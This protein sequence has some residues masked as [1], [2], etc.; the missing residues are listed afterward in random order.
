MFDRRVPVLFFTNE[1]EKVS[2]EVT[3]LKTFSS[4]VNG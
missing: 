2:K 3:G 4:K 1:E